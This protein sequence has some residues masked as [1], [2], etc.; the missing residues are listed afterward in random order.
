MQGWATSGLELR[1]Q[2]GEGARGCNP[3]ADGEAV[4]WEGADLRAF[5]WLGPGGSGNALECSVSGS[6]V[7]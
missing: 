5:A 3:H 2:E 1:A 7:S 6:P 4:L